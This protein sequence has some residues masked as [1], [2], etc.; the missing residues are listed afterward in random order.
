[1]SD[2]HI[3]PILGNLPRALIAL[4]L[5]AWLFTGSSAF[6]KGGGGGGGKPGLP[7]SQR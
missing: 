1:M 4:S 2:R 7:G 6:A 5:T 3:R